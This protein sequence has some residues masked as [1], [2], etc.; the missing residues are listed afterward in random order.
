MRSLEDCSGPWVGFWIQDGKRGN[1][2]LSLTFLSGRILG[3]GN[4]DNGPFAIAGT[5]GSDGGVEATKMYGHYGFRYYG[6]WDGAMI[7]G[8][9]EQIGFPS[10]GSQFEMWPEG[11]DL[12]LEEIIAERELTRA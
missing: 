8:Y 3:G 12:T 5:Y 9:S 6:H 2:R 7:F 4:D 10:N 1:M 11:E